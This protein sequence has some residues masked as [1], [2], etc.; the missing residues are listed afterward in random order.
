[1]YLD[2]QKISSWKEPCFQSRVTS[3]V[4]VDYLWTD[5]SHWKNHGVHRSTIRR[6]SARMGTQWLLV[7]REG[8]RVQKS[9]YVTVMLLWGYWDCF[10]FFLCCRVWNFL[11]CCGCGKEE[12]QHHHQQPEGGAL[13]PHR[14][15]QDCRLGCARGVPHW[16]WA[17]GSNGMWPSKRQELQGKDLFSNALPM[18]LAP[19]VCVQKYVTKSCC[20]GLWCFLYDSYV[21]LMKTAGFWFF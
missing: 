10:S 4:R 12:L 3:K 16:H 1:M 19:C 14:H 8:T 20:F 2:S 7:G 17:P 5:N 6:F 9:V 21:G 13:L 11:L 15:Q 18:V